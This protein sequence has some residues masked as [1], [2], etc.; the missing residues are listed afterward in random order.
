MSA[1]VDVL[2]EAWGLLAKGAGD[3]GSAWRVLTLANV[4]AEGAPGARS[5]VLRGVDAQARVAIVHSDLRSPKIAGLARD[6]RTALLGWDAGRRV[7]IRLDGV[8]GIAGPAETDA[9]WEALPEASR[10]TYAGALA[11]GT[12]MDAPEATLGM[13]DRSIFAVLRLEVAAIEYL[14]LRHG[15]HRRARFGWLDGKLAATWLAP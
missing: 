8:I 5:V 11:P 12:P 6:R 2:S 7:Q 9:A 14:S 15:A 13:P 10:A 3:P 4:T 1:L